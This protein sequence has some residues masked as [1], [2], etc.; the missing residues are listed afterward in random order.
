[1]QTIIGAMGASRNAWPTTRARY[2][3]EGHEIAARYTKGKS[4][5]R[6]STALTGRGV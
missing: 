1:V 5:A 3:A 6:Q 4:S 2:V